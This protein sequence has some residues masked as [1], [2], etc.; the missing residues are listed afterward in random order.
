MRVAA[1]ASDVALRLE[2]VQ[3]L[4]LRVSFFVERRSAPRPDDGVPSTPHA[5]AA[6]VCASEPAATL[7]IA[8]SAG[9][10]L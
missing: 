3:Q 4:S 2:I 9:V 7:P 6:C 10:C 1:C 5:S 8:R